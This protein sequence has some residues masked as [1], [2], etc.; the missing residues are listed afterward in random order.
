MEWG[1]N[2]FFLSGFTLVRIGFL[3]VKEVV[4]AVPILW[5]SLL[6]F[7]Q[8]VAQEDGCSNGWGFIIWFFKRCAGQKTSHIFSELEESLINF[9]PSYRDVISQMS[10]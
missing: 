3:R 6:E 4:S 7:T 5:V 8:Q 9:I 10:L 2:R 1:I